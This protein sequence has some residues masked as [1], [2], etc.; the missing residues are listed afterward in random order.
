MIAVT[1][2]KLWH[3]RD[4]MPGGIGSTEVWLRRVPLKTIHHG[5]S[6]KWG[7]D[8]MELAMERK[9]SIRFLQKVD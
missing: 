4:E 1:L 9:N 2:G 5:K 7:Q 3:L 8:L 6:C